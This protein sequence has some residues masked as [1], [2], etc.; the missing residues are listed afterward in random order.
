LAFFAITFLGRLQP[1]AYAWV[2]STLRFQAEIDL[3]QLA[4][5]AHM[6]GPPSLSSLAR[7][8]SSRVTGGYL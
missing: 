7:M 8:P 4:I 5:S 3:A 2:G 6:V 1:F